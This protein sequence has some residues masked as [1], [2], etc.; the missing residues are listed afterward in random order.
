LLSTAEYT[1]LLA[2]LADPS[3]DSLWV[4][5]AFFYMSRFV[6]MHRNTYQPSFNYFNSIPLQFLKVDGITNDGFLSLQKLLACCPSIH[7][8]E[9]NFACVPNDTDVHNLITFL[10]ERPQK[11]H[12]P[13]QYLS[14]QT[15]GNA[16]NILL[17][18]LSSIPPLRSLTLTGGPLQDDQAIQLALFLASKSCSLTSLNLLVWS[19]IGCKAILSALK[20]NLVITQLNLAEFVAFDKTDKFRFADILPTC[21]LCSLKMPGYDTYVNLVDGMKSSTLTSLDL[22]GCYLFTS[23]LVKFAQ[24]SLSQTSIALPRLEALQS[25]G[26]YRLSHPS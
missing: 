5:S 16:T 22:L 23:D 25:P 10:K 17:A 1:K 13:I 3:D 19:V 2:L 26:S 15:S 7:A 21:A 11:Q 12:T 6:E 18:S 20:N 4:M 9:I 24:N 14:F 8:L